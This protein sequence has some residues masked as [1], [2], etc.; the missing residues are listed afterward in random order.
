[1]KKI[2]LLSIKIKNFKGI[3]DF[4]LIEI[5][6]VMNIHGDNG[7]FKTSLFDAVSWLLFGKNSIGETKFGIKRNDKE[8]NPIEGL[9]ISVEGLL[10]INGEHTK[11]Y[12]AQSETKSGNVQEF[13][14]ND[15]PFKSTEYSK[16]IDE[17]CTEQVFKLITNPAS[18]N[19][20]KWEDKRQI[21]V[22]IAGDLKV[23]FGDFAEK[24]KGKD[25]ELYQ[26]QLNSEVKEVKKEMDQ[27]PTRISEVELSLKNY[28]EKEYKALEEKLSK[29]DI[30]KKAVSK[31]DKLK[32]E[33]D[34]FSTQLKN[35][36]NT[37]KNTRDAEP[38]IKTECPTCS[39]KLDENLINKAKE[40]FEQ[41]K[42]AELK[43]L[44]TEGTQLANDLAEHNINIKKGEEF[45]ESLQIDQKDIERYVELKNLSN[46]N[47]RLEELKQQEQDLAQTFADKEHDLFKING[48]VRQ[49]M[50]ML[51]EVVNSKF[52][53][54]EFRLFDHLDK[55]NCITMV[56]CKDSLVNYQDANTAS[57]I[58]AGVDIINVLCN[59]YKVNAPI[60]IDNRESVTNLLETESQLFNLIVDKKCKRLTVK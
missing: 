11:L 36:Q 34:V 2:N 20:L 13:K 17:I 8:G 40:K 16:K 22:S 15:V 19:A 18:F 33:A 32:R 55:P 21:L 31:L 28:D 42:K 50:E 23:D 26:R 52:S 4:E 48:F 3:E 43:S 25:L 51:E 60:F 12:R 53:M 29:K 41:N 5:E 45:V 59:Y 7:T 14:V 35:L 1:M 9:K 44:T 39:T 57:K 10:D 38:S 27:I 54:V 49:K 37:Y 24:L 56:K 47:N 58:N 30:Y 46:L 6:Q